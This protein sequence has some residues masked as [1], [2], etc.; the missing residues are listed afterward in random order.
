MPQNKFVIQPTTECALA[1]VYKGKAEEIRWGNPA[2]MQSIRMELMKRPEYK[3]GL[4]QVRRK[5]AVKFRRVI[6]RK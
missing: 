5:G 6:D 2:L 3:C 4:L 1:F